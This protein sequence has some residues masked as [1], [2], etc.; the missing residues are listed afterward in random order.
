MRFT[1]LVAAL[2]LSALA[3]A[4]SEAGLSWTVPSNWKNLGART[5]RVA[6]YEAPA[7][8]GDKDPAE[9]AVFYFGEGQGGGVQANIDR[10]I[11]QFEGKPAIPPKPTVC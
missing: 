11:S 4:D 5:M 9:I 6:T 1:L 7:A 8:A 3:W 2:G 10:W